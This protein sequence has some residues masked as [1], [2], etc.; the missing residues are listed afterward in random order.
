MADETE[1]QNSRDYLEATGALTGPWD[2]EQYGN[3]ALSSGPCGS[4]F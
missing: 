2:P 3:W 4:V 1:Y